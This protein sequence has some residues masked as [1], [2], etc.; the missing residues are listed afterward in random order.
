MNVVDVIFLNE[1]NVSFKERLTS[2]KIRQSSR[3][4]F[5]GKIHTRTPSG[6]KDV[7]CIKKENYVTGDI[8]DSYTYVLLSLRKS[9]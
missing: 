1:K 3:I 2:N 8:D 4:I 9:K 7:G 5:L 6:R